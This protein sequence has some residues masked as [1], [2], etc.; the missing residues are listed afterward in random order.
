MNQFTVESIDDKLSLRLFIKKKMKGYSAK[1]VETLLNSNGC[2]VNRKLERFGSTKLYKGDIVKIFPAFVEANKISDIPI[3]FEDEHLCVIDK[4]SGV[5][6]AL[7]EIE[8]RLHKKLFLVHRLD[9]MT[10]GVLLLAKTPLAQKKME[11]LFFERA[12]EKYYVALVHGRVEKPR[13]EIDQPITLQK[14]FDGGVVY[15]ASRFGKK[16]KTLYKRLAANK[17]ES[18]LYLKPITGRTHQIRVHLSSIEHPILG[19]SLY[20]KTSLSSHRP[21]RL[22]L[23][24]YK[25]SFT[26]P[27]TEKKMAFIAPI[28]PLMN[29]SIQKLFKKFKLCDF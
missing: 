16:A 6:S 2:E 21:S 23:H 17:D 24:A 15:K 7:E 11:A 18:L 3:L 28:A 25:V 10:S 20:K 1:Q 4:P 12:I 14:R 5:S 26:H 27:F 19:D 13:G 29:Q 8:K 9:K 22:L